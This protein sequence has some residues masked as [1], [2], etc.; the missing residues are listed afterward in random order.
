MIP[1]V[2]E[3][4]F[5]PVITHWSPIKVPPHSGILSLSE[6]RA[7]RMPTS[8][9]WRALSAMPIEELPEG[10]DR[11]ED[12]I[13]QATGWEVIKRDQLI[14]LVPLCMCVFLI[15]GD[16]LNLLCGRWFVV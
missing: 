1:S 3:K 5:A 7:S 16:D 6:S 9:G 13:P 10:G 15:T 14:G 2:S 8:H 4:H 11:G 12:V